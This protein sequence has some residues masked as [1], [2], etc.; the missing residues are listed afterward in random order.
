MKTPMLPRLFLA[1]CFVPVPSFGSAPFAGGRWV[2]LTHDFSSE[3]IY[4]P[5]A[6][7]FALETE[8]RGVTPNGYFYC[9]N[10]YHASEH[11]GTHIDAPIHFA[12][13]GKPVD[14]LAIDQLTGAAIVVDVSAAAG[15]DADYL[16]TIADLKSWEEK[17]G[18]IPNAAI[19]LFH[20]GF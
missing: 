7:G 15:K 3:T 16:I 14:Q 17:H 10:R 4:W 20:T 18:Q 13:G 2:D 6:Q 11:G 12:E 9:A 5:T 1:L 19:V 8:F